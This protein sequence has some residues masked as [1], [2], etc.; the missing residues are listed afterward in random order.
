M[1]GALQYLFNCVAHECW[2]Q[3]ALGAVK[4]VGGGLTVATGAAIC[5]TV[6][7]CAL[8]A[9][10]AAFGASD[11]WQGGGMVIDAVQGIS[12]EGFNLIKTGFQ[13]AM[14]EWG[15]AAYEGT[16]LGFNVAAIGAKVPLIVGASDGI[17][18][19]NSMF[20]VAVSRWDNSRVMLG[21]VLSQSMNRLMLTGSAF[22]KAFGFGKEVDAAGNGP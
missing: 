20:G 2:K 7:G 17:G 18:R 21:N 12:S 16:S 5:T 10:M 19:V 4:A 13:L 3:G 22:G 8:G 11:A 14:P 1:S 6:A 15:G 9:P